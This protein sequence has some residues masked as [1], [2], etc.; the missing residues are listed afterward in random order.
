MF[1]DIRP[2]DPSVPHTQLQKL[3]VKNGA[4]LLLYKYAMQFYF[5]TLSGFNKDLMT[6]DLEVARAKLLNLIEAS[7]WEGF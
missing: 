7:I 1:W 4:L 5:R 3:F 2:S 6:S